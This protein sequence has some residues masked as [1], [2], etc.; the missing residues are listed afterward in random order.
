M[1]RKRG[2]RLAPNGSSVKNGRRRPGPSR[3]GPGGMA[4]V[5]SGRAGVFKPAQI[6]PRGAKD[7]ATKGPAGR[8]VTR[9][10]WRPRGRGV[11]AK[12]TGGHIRGEP[13]AP[14]GSYRPE[15]GCGL[16]RAAGKVCFSRQR[17]GE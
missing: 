9:R 5:T 7:I 4:G 6:P 11:T 17:V 13:P 16:R 14:R 15:Q 8:A 12:G 3:P 10:R 1:A 2:A